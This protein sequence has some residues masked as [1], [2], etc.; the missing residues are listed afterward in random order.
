MEKSIIIDGIDVSGCRYIDEW[1]HCKLCQELVKTKMNI[2]D[3]PR[4]TCVDV[5]DLEC[6]YYDNCYYK[7]LQRKAAECESLRKQV[8]CLTKRLKKCQWK[9]AINVSSGG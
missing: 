9:G 6:S 1:K 2:E 7:Q 8:S 4:T 3:K 5:Q